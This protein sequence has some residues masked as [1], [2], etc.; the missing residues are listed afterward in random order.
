MMVE[1]VYH[2]NT[3]EY[4]GEVDHVHIR[5]PYRTHGG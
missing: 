4:L 2:V 1:M 5:P 3:S